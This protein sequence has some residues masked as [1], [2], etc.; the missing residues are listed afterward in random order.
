MFDENIKNKVFDEPQI[1]KF[2]CKLII[3]TQYCDYKYTDYDC[4][5]LEYIIKSHSYNECFE[6]IKNEINQL[7]NNNK[8]IYN[9]SYYGYDWEVLEYKIDSNLNDKLNFNLTNK[10]ESLDLK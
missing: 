10:L 8:I 6:K 4:T 5:S 2:E 9:E 1:F 7:I 3:K